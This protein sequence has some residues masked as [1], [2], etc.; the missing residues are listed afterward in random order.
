MTLHV[1]TLFLFLGP[2]F[3][4]LGAGVSVRARRVTPQARTWLILGVVFSAVALWLR[5]TG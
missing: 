3:L 4:L 1:P 5:A 2:L